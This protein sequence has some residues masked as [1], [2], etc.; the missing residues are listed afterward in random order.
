MEAIADFFVLALASGPGPWTESWLGPYRV[1]F[2]LNAQSKHAW[3]G[4]R[5][6]SLA[7][8]IDTTVAVS[9]RRSDLNRDNSQ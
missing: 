1:F 4:K 2:I 9:L 3:K 7:Y 5:Y 6:Q 8:R